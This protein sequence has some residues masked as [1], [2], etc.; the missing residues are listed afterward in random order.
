MSGKNLD[1]NDSAPLPNNPLTPAEFASRMAALGPFEI[2]PRVAIACSGGADSLAATLCADHWARAMGGHATALI[3]D[4]AMRPDSSEEAA[5]V[6]GWLDARAIDT[7]ILTRRGPPLAADRQA[8]AR[9]ARYALM[10]GW[11]RA[12]GVLHLVLGHHRQDQAETVL[13]RLAR[14]SGV[15]GLAGMA[16]VVEMPDVRLLRP[17]LDLPRGR[18]IAFLRSRGQKF[19]VDPS[20]DDPLYARTRLRRMQP[21]LAAEGITDARLAGTAR[22]MARARLALESA[23]TDLLASTTTLYPQGYARL[24]PAQLLAAPE[25]IG[26]RALARLLICI[27]GADYTPRLDRIEALYGWLRTGQGDGRTLGGCRVLRRSAGILVCRETSAVADPVA[28]VDGA[29][30]DGRFRLRLSGGMP[31]GARLGPLGRE[32]WARLCADRPDLRRSR[33]PAVVRQTLPALSDLDGVA[34]VPHLCYRQEPDPNRAFAKAEIV[35]CPAR[36][37]GGAPFAVGADFS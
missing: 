4:H 26:L 3:V 29:R 17:L 32:G 14:G 33:L 27:G 9:R 22:R 16:P 23:A 18:L 1:A 21:A 25:E 36:P 11:C 6:A 13:L 12:A 28:A 34:R 35:F 5:T 15:H 7:V 20:N 8:A 24:A 37:L 30:W 31:K 2:A 10:T 19:V